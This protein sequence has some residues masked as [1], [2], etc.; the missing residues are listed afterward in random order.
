ML[1]SSGLE[2]VSS[3]S[4]R[5]IK[6]RIAKS[7]SSRVAAC[8]A[9]THFSTDGLANIPRLSDDLLPKAVFYPYIRNSGVTSHYNTVSSILTGQWQHLDDWGKSRPASPTLFEYL[10]KQMQLSAEKTW[11]VSSNK[12][13]TSQ[14]GAS[15]FANSVL[16]LART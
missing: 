7:S 3:D 9:R 13:L 2:R 12:A 5:G 8:A 16:H 15:A 1:S 4:A 11:L 6:M 10:R 14:I